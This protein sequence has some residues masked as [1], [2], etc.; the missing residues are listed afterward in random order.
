MDRLF[1]ILLCLLSAAG[2]HSRLADGPGVLTAIGTAAQSTN[3]WS[4]S[5]SGGLDGL[6]RVAQET[7]AIVRRP[8]TGLA[9]GTAEVWATLDGKP[10]NVQFDGTDGDGRWRANVETTNGSHALWVYAVHPSGVFTNSTNSTFTLTGGPDTVTNAYDSNGNLTTRVWLNSSGSV[11]RSQ[12]LTWDAFDRLIKVA[13]RDNVNNGQDWAGI[14]DS[15]GRKVRTTTTLVVSNTPITTPASAVSTV[16]SWFDPLVEFLEGAV[17]VN[18]GVL[19]VKTY[20]PDANGVYGGLD[21]VGG[22]ERIEP[23]GKMNPVGMVQDFFGN[24]IGLAR[25]GSTHRI[26][27]YCSCIR[28][29]N[30]PK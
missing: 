18:G 10:I 17:A 6:G 11:R 29:P 7:T 24:V 26:V 8:A 28:R 22:L 19:S 4:V 14:Y 13:D 25:K 9:L 1:C 23:Y 15:L 27:H 16:D 21:G 12:T 20:G 3:A 5:P 30:V 2:A